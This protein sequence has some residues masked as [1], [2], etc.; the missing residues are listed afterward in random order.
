LSISAN[1]WIAVSESQ[2]P[3]E[4][5]ALAWLREHL[6]DDPSWRV[7]SNFEF[8]ADNGSIN[9]V[10]VLVLSPVGL[11]LVEIK[12]RPG[13]L[14]GDARTWTWTT[15]G[16]RFLDDNPIYLADKKAK[17]LKSLLRSQEAFR[18]SKLTPPRIE[19]LI[20]VSAEKLE[21]RLEGVARARVHGR[22]RPITSGEPG[23]VAALRGETDI[24]SIAGQ[25]L[26]RRVGGAT[27]SRRASGRRTGIGGSET[28]SWSSC[29]RRG[30]AIRNGRR[31]TS[32]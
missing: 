2:F 11:F 24:P 27:V 21:N 15:D 22:D 28:S 7:W 20:F 13:R 1:R 23:I 3:W 18:K 26:D 5:E 4:R 19:A 8:V 6:P 10:D 9:E 12:S 25:R 29:C 17:R 14:E 31:R 30:S 16:R 32:A